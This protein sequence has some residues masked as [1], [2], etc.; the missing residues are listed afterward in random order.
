M[1]GGLAVRILIYSWNW[2]VGC[3]IGKVGNN[4]TKVGSNSLELGSKYGKD[5]SKTG[6]LI[7]GG[8]PKPQI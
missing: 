6:N 3:K 5:G 4:S 8:P 2:I 7:T 1:D